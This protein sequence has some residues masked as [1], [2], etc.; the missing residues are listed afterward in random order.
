MTLSGI[1]GK[2]KPIELQEAILGNV[3]V[4]YYIQKLV[5]RK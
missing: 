1:A 4:G 5:I 3:V 2:M